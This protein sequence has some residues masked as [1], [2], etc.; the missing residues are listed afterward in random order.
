[1]KY[2]AELAN[3]DDVE[4]QLHTPMCQDGQAQKAAAT[5][6]WINLRVVCN[7]DMAYKPFYA[8]KHIDF[9]LFIRIPD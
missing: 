7:N 1:M 5:I 6:S 9:D 4:A 3:W 2:S 8:L